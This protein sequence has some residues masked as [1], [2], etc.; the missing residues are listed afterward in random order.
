MHAVV[1]FLDKKNLRVVRSFSK[2]VN[3]ALHSNEGLG[4]PLPHISY[5]GAS[6]YDMEKLEAILQKFASQSRRFMVHVGGLGIFTGFT[7]VLYIPVVRTSELSKFHLSLWRRISSVGSGLS[8]YYKPDRWSPHITL[9]RTG[10]SQRTL[11]E[12]IGKLA[13]KELELDITIDNLA[14]IND[15]NGQYSVRSRFPIG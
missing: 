14:I 3:K 12:I 9:A 4:T 1:S 10:V 15:N 13:R 8:E 2:D 5:Q 6:E 7:P 11:T